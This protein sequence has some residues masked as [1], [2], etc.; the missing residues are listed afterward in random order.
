MVMFLYRREIISLLETMI[1]A[2]DVSQHGD[3]LAHFKVH[4]TVHTIDTPAW[5]IK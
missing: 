4:L 5:L 1:L 2:T 3:F